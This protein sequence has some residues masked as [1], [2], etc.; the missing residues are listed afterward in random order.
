MAATIK[1]FNAVR[2]RLFVDEALKANITYL[3]TRRTLFQMFVAALDR[4][5]D[6]DINGQE[7]IQVR[8]F[9]SSREARPSDQARLAYELAID[10]WDELLG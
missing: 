10:S 8:T 1:K 6:V 2:L 9:L 7:Y 4:E 5:G 3:A